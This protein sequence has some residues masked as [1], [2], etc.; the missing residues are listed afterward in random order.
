MR[1]PLLPF[2]TCLL[3]LVMA[4]WNLKSQIAYSPVIDSLINL[5]T[6]A[7]VSLTVREL[8]GDTSALIGGTVQTITSRNYQYNPMQNIAAQY[9]KEKFESYGLQAR[10]QNY[11]SSGR[12]IIGWKTGTKYPD[13]K[14]I[15][16]A[17]MDDMPS[18]AF[19]PGA[20][21]NASGVV[22]VL[23]AARILSSWP[24]EYTLVF[25]A[26]DEEEIGLVG[27]E[28]Y[29]DSAAFN[30][31]QIIGVLNYDMIAWDS[32]NDYKMSIGTNTLSQSLT[33]DYEDIL[34][35]YT[36]EINWNYI[37]IEASD[38]SSFWHNGYPAILGIEEYPGDF[39]EY[40]HTQ[41]DQFSILN[42]PFFTRMV[43]AS[44]AGLATLGWNCRLDI[45][46][47]PVVSGDDTNPREAVFSVLSPRPI[48]GGSYQPRL[49][50]KTN[51]NEYQY[52]LPVS[53]ANNQF[54]FE[55]PGQQPGTAVSYYFAVQDSA[56]IITGTLPEGGRGINP[57][58]T[59][60]PGTPFTYYIAPVQTVTLC[61]NTTPVPIPDL[62]SVYD[63][64]P[65][66]ITGGV[67]DIDVTVNISHTMDKTLNISLISPQGSV[68]NL[69]S[70]NGGNN[71]NYTGTIF[72]DEASVSILM[73]SAPFTGR[74]K[75]EQPLSTFDNTGADGKWVIRVQDSIISHTGT[76]DSWCVTLGYYDMTVAV[77]EYTQASGFSL[78]QNFPNP[79][80][81][82]TTI[83]F[84]LEREAKVRLELFD[85]Y[86][87][88]I[89]TLAEGTYP[90]GTCFIPFEPSGYKPGTY[91]YRLANGSVS[92]TKAL[93]IVR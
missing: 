40:Y 3:L 71:S 90:A 44:V 35:M 8:S 92:R 21:D 20:D 77:P 70:G 34:R 73:G 49:Y 60:A 18:N 81:A 24:S 69:S 74:F 42:I 80:T 57:P 47:Q 14:Y 85:L 83:P 84:N 32:N 12:N 2:F 28:A 39:N 26:W 52:L 37:S 54:T 36:P 22:A 13:K 15:I 79:V 63:T 62:G 23:E 38:H 75:P 93:L 59:V 86:G 9:I 89:S 7:T 6:P 88:K 30:G 16:C 66:N 31:E 1:K 65:V 10:Y 64:I 25:A 27:S 56:G 11:S 29:S 67:Q 51:G 78:G 33:N 48:E 58:G 50:Y 87:R 82:S 53:S 46:H 55:I 19:A 17:H 43:Q 91:F 68:V 45:H 72:D 41:Q 5:A 4:P 61:S 76:L